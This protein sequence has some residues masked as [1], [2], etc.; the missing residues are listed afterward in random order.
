MPKVTYDSN[1]FIKRKPAPFPAGF[2]LSVVVLQELV[3][4]ARDA[5]AIKELEGIRRTYQKEDRLLVPTVEDWWAVGVII[6]SLQRVRKSRKTGLIPRMRADEKYRITNDVLIARTAQ[7]AGVTLVTDNISD[8]KKIKNFCNVK[9]ISG[10]E[11][12]GR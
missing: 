5:S 2:Y 12:F 7:R 8:F 1:I 4:G 6:N 10:A 3:A 9:L 11:F